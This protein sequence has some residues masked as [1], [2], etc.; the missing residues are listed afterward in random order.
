MTTQFK[1]KGFTIIEL[2]IVIVVIGILATIT[3]VALG[4]ANER[5]RDAK[6]ESDVKSLQTAL[7]AYYT[8]G[9]SHYPTLANMNDTT[10]RGDN[11]QGLDGSVYEDPNGTDDQLASTPAESVYAYEPAPSGC[12]NTDTGGM[13]TEYT[14]TA[15]ME[16]DGST[17]V[18]TNLQ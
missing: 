4:G 16:G 13:C 15:T 7:E 9:N 18:R 3:A 6:R 14:L 11:F 5:A 10:F 1:Q 8:V 12:D 17:L 2:L